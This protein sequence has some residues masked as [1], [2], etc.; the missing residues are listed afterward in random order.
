V[1]IYVEGLLLDCQ[2][3]AKNVLDLT[4]LHLPPFPDSNVSGDAGIKPWTVSAF[5]LT[6]IAVQRVLN[7]L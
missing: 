3:I 2:I 5:A 1:E 7:S 6:V 4:L